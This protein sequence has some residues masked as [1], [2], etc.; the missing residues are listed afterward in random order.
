[1]IEALLD[2]PPHVRERSAAALEAGLLSVA[3]SKAELRSVLGNGDDVEAA[4]SALAEFTRLGVSGNASARWIRSLSRVEAR[5]PRS[6][7]VWSGSKVSGLHAR[8]TRRSM[9]K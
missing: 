4:G 9:K 6:D 7:L 3:A 1:M 5:A 2:L 8:D